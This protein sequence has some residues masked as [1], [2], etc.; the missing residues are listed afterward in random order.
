VTGS[1]PKPLTC[2]ILSVSSCGTPPG[3]IA[4][5][6]DCLQPGDKLALE[7]ALVASK[8]ERAILCEESVGHSRKQEA[9]REVDRSPTEF[10]TAPDNV[11]CLSPGDTPLRTALGLELH[12]F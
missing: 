12:L 4:T 3:V 8:I 10:S 11:T 1:Q 5:P 6:P 9:G 2:G 7:T